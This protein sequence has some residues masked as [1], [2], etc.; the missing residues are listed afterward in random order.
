MENKLEYITNKVLAERLLE[1]FSEGLLIKY[2]HKR[3]I[4]WAVQ[5]LQM[6]Y[7]NDNLYI[8]AGA[9]N[10]TTEEQEK[11]FWKILDELKFEIKTDDELI[12]FYAV[13][14]AEKA[15]KKEINIDVA[16]NIMLDIVSATDYD[17]RYVCF[18]QIHVD[19]DC[20][21]STNQFTNL[22]GLTLNNQK[23]YI[24]KEFEFFLET[25]RLKISKED[26]SKFYCNKCKVFVNWKTKKKFQ[27]KKPY[28]HY[29][30]ICEICGSK[31][32]LY[33]QNHSTLK[34]LI[35]KYRQFEN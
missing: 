8:L 11:Y 4:N 23:E 13:D 16:F 33:P 20:L 28:W 21:R 19:L 30:F 24:L 10:D 18:Y 26:L 5:V 15:V 34:L 35:E 17:S 25:R 1:P 2:D 27:L 9:D 14:I 3:L 32:L 6:G 12:D 7:E 29:I 22:D 31:D